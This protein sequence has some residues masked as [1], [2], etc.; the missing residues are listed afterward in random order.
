MGKYKLSIIIPAYN[1]ENYLPQLLACLDKQMVPGVEVII[2]DDGSTDNSLQIAKEYEQNYHP[3][4]NRSVF[5]NDVERYVK[6]I[7]PWE[8]GGC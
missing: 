5:S 3:L 2:I 1:A 8:R 4:T 6:D 7:W